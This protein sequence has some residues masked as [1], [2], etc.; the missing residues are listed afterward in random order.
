[1]DGTTLTTS[2]CHQ[3]AVAL[4]SVGVVERTLPAP[5]DDYDYYL[6]DPP[7]VFREMYDKLREMDIPD[8]RFSLRVSERRLSP[9]FRL[10]Q[11]QFP[12]K[13]SLIHLGLLSLGRTQMRPEF[14]DQQPSLILR[15][16]M[17]WNLSLVAAAG[18]VA[19]AGR[20][21]SAV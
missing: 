7:A 6:C 13:V 11:K 20:R 4:K 18:H 17:D 3:G 10:N 12:R 9:E 5:D 19:R 2:P 8:S 1:M 16:R 14:Q 21:F 15:N